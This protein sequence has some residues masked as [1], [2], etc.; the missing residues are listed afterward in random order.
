MGNDLLAELGT[1]R[2]AHLAGAHL[3]SLE[4]PL[5]DLLRRATGPPDLHRIRAAQAAGWDVCLILTPSAYRWSV[6]E[7]PGELDELR[8]L[9]GHPVRHQNK[10]PSEPDMLPQ[11]DAILVAPLTATTVNKWAAGISDTLAL[12]LLT[13]AIGLELPIVALEQRAKRPPCRFPERGPPT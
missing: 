10:L 11:P 5:P 1:W 12:G 9:T 3:S 7:A 6:K 2:S 4:G 8:D 13:E